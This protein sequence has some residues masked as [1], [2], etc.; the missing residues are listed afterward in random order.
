[1]AYKYKYSPE[2][3]ARDGQRIAARRAEWFARFGGVCCK[4]GSDENLQVDHV[5]PSKK[6]SH[7]VFSWCDEK[8]EAEL[9]KC[10]PLC[11][12]CHI[13]K[14][15]AWYLENLPH[16][17]SGAY[18]KHGCRCEV[19]MDYMRECSKRKRDKR[20]KNKYIPRKRRPAESPIDFVAE[21]K[22]FR[23]DRFSP[24]A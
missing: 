20:R 8:R 5:D 10:Q 7:R 24:C 11:Q 23:A 19:C 9:G 3:Q 12:Q 6:I 22:V 13:N 15:R 21:C 14:T 17:N 18:N 2:K 1:M 4:C 16:G